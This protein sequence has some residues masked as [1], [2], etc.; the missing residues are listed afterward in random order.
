MINDLK[1]IAKE[2]GENLRI[3]ASDVEI[4]EYD[5]QTY[6]TIMFF[7]PISNAVELQKAKLLDD[8]EKWLYKSLSPK[9]F[10]PDMSISGLIAADKTHTKSSHFRYII[11]KVDSLLSLKSIHEKDN[12]FCLYLILHEFGH[13]INF[14]L[15][16]RNVYRLRQR[17]NQ[18]VELKKKT[19]DMIQFIK[20]QFDSNSPPDAFEMSILL[21]YQNLYYLMPSEKDANDFADEKFTYFYNLLD[22]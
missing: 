18:C 21:C 6:K 11:D 14:D 16:D 13:Y 19:E 1:D 15:Y 22:W 17:D 9:I 2:V 20:T 8:E 12:A 4:Y 3:D 10:I 5:L 7:K